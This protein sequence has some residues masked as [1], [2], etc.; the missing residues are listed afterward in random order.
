MGAWLAG[1]AAIIIGGVIVAVIVVVVTGN[2]D[3]NGPPPPPP[4]PP[5]PTIKELRVDVEAVP[6]EIAAGGS[7]LIQVRVVSVIG[8][9][10]VDA[11]VA[12]HVGGG[13]FDGSGTQ[14]FKGKT[15]SF[16]R[17]SG[18]WTSPP[19]SANI[20]YIFIARATA[21]G[22]AEAAGEVIVVVTP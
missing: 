1:L 4:P 21:D 22:F 5:P 3:G 17:F 12:L 14:D 18:K 2:G 19:G 9:A 6:Q 10:P 7:S 20:N 11:E 8:N 15:N 13:S 16:G